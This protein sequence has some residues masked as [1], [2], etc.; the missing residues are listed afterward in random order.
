M[1]GV[2]DPHEQHGSDAGQEGQDHADAAQPRQGR[3]ARD[4]GIVESQ[5][6]RN[7]KGKQ[8]NVVCLA[9]QIINL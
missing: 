1:D 2:Q 6:R 4:G 8:T 7:C 3:A 9:A 5:E